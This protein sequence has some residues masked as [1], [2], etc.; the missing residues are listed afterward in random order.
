MEVRAR[1]QVRG[2]SDLGSEVGHAE[3]VAPDLTPRGG[4]Q[5]RS[6]EGRL[7]VDTK[8]IDDAGLLLRDAL[9]AAH[10]LA[11]VAHGA[12]ALDAVRTPERRDVEVPCPARSALS[13]PHGNELD[14]ATHRACRSH[15]AVGTWAEDGVR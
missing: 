2:F 13:S 8:R 6:L 4:T 10:P 11:A 9:E 5:E 12:Y 7:V 1:A 15:R 14:A 3:G